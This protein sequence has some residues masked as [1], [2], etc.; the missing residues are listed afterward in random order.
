M[1]DTDVDKNLNTPNVKLDGR[2]DGRGRMCSPSWSAPAVT[3]S[4]GLNSLALPKST[5]FRWP[6]AVSKTFSGC[7]TENRKQKTETG[8]GEAVDERRHTHTYTHLNVCIHTHIDTY[9]YTHTHDHTCMNT[10]ICIHAS[11]HVHILQ[12]IDYYII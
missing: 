8:I 12:N 9:T 3:P 10:K 4:R 7:E 1:R 5:S 11:V 6:S 2:M